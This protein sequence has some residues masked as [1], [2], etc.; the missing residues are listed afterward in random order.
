MIFILQF[1][2]PKRKDNNFFPKGQESDEPDYDQCLLRF[3]FEKSEATRTSQYEI[4]RDE[5]P[6]KLA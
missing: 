6:Q 2:G 1:H 5:S 3:D 4:N